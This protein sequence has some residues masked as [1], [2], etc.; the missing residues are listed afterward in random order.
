MDLG[1]D[2]ALSQIYLT[3]N[4]LYIDLTLSAV[5][6]LNTYPMRE[7]TS[8]R[9]FPT[10]LPSLSHPPCLWWHCVCETLGRGKVYQHQAD[11]QLKVS[12]NSIHQIRFLPKPC[13]TWQQRNALSYILLGI[14]SPFHSWTQFMSLILHISKWN[15]L[16]KMEN[17]GRNLIVIGL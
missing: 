14:C 1:G 4:I 10:F 11:W 9:P 7:A 16:I 8:Q 12:C 17:V 2:N 15:L 5:N 3:T 13:Q 6:I